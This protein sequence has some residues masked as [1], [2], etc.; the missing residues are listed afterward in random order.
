M[1]ERALL[2]AWSFL[3]LASCGGSPPPQPAKTTTSASTPPPSA[4]TVA[5]PA[6]SEPASGPVAPDVPSGAAAQRDGVL[7]SDAER[8][9]ATFS[10][11]DPSLSLDGKK[12]VF[13]SNRDGLSQLYLAEVGKPDAPV[14]RLT[15][16][17]QRTVG[18]AFSAD[19]KSV[20]FAS[21]RGADE[22]FSI[23]RI[24]VDGNGLEELTP[25]E[26]LRRDPPFMPAGAPDTLV[27]SARKK[28]ERTV[29]VYVQS[30]KGGAPSKPVYTDSSP[31]KLLAVDR[32][33]KRALLRRYISHSETAL[34][35]IDLASGQAK[36]V[37]PAQG[38]MVTL[39]S[40]AFS[41]DGKT[42]FVATDDGTEGGTLLALD[43]TTSAERARYVD[44]TLKTAAMPEVAV[45][46]QGDRVAIRLDAGNRSVVRILDARRLKP[47]AEAQLPLGSG[48]GLAASY[49]GK[50]FALQWSTPNQP[51]DVFLVDARKGAAHAVPKEARPTLAGLGELEATVQTIPSFDGTPIP[52]NIY[53]PKG[54]VA[55]T[56]KYPVLVSVH[57]GPAGSYPV[58]W[59]TFVRFYTAHGFIVVE[60]NVRGS[61][62]F[63]RAYE[64]AD[65][66][67]KRMDAIKDLEAVGKWVV[68]NPWA[69]AARLVLHGGSYGGYMT[70]MGLA[71]HPTLWKAGVDLFG[72]YDW[73]S[74]MRSTSGEIRSVFQTEIG[75]E[76][77]NAFLASISP[78]TR[79][80]SIS[81]PLFVYA[82]ANDPRV[83]RS[84]SDQIV[85]SLRTRKVSVEYMVAENEGHSLDRKE[86][87]TSFLARSTRFLEDALK[88]ERQ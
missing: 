56:K 31:G 5:A 78:A 33:G 34:V 77:D 69:D 62:G 48:G 11:G 65:D 36:T 85:R 1:N 9:V 61:T 2:V 30:L 51:A 22:N 41:G 64:Q 7:V 70:L 12:V 58:R 72:V 23:F 84:E 46:R 50:S 47:V 67:P 88:L 66:G 29:R 55:G 26:T 82:G 6:P 73:R 35:L 76:T 15:K 86:N 54:L 63:G 10:N 40:A 14:V 80:D 79:V 27:Y 24:G 39:E 42:I 32:L 57:G 8:I 19:G 81:V 71:H 25:G 52:L 37:Y 87:I 28:E 4:T 74:F 44:A 45:A 17:G 49:D 68:Q 83:P 3:L 75:P 38:K 59:S 20:I 21:D 60:P 13:R 18:P 43:A 16:T 53:K